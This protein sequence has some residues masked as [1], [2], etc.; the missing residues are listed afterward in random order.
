MLPDQPLPRAF[1]ARP[2]LSVARDCIGKHLVHD[3]AQ[4]RVRG[5]IVEAEAYRGPEDRAAH[6][7]GGRRTQRTEVMFGPP[8]Y[9]YVFLVYG[10]HWHFNI[11]TTRTGAPH[12]VLIRAVE[13]L[14]GLELMARRR[15]L[16]A[17][18][19]ELTNGPGKLCLAFGIDRRAYGADLTRGALFLSD[20]ARTRTARSPRIGIDY[21][22][23]WAE[24]PWRFYDPSS[25]YVSRRPAAP[26]PRSTRE[27]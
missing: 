10:L 9:A 1:Y 21:A 17:S 27:D 8:G 7:F 12:A 16:P 20:G 4:G 23:D 11:V 14:E 25:P 26:L 3:T 18:R 15:G 6:S 2:V 22:G 13:P 19:R 5:R 24:R